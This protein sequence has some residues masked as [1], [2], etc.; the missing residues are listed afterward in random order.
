[1]RLAL[2][3]LF[4][5]L[6]VVQ[7][8]GQN[9]IKT[10]NEFLPHALGDQFTPHHLQVDYFQYLAAQAPS[11]MILQQY[12]QTY[13]ARPLQVAIIS[14]PE[15]ISRL[16]QIRVN[17]LRLA[18]LAEGSAD[19]I[20]PPAI[21]WLSM[22]VHGNEPSG[23]ECSMALA[24]RLATQKD[25]SVRN[26][27]KNTVVIIDPSL[28]PD[29]YDRY[30]HWNRMAGNLIKNPGHSS[31]EHRE[32]WPSGRVNHYYFDLNRDWA[33]GAQVETRHRLVLYQS[34]LPHIH[35]DLHEQYPENPYYFAPAAEPMHAYITPWQRDF[36]AEIG[37]NHAFYFDQSGWLY[38]T[39][40]V[41]D[42]FYP[43]YGDTYPIFNGSIGM[44]YEQAG[45]G[46]A[47]RAITLN[48][49]DT[50]T[51]YDRIAHHMTTSLS[52]IEMASKNAERVVTN[53]RQYYKNTAAQPQGPYKT[54]VIQAGNDPNKIDALCRLLDM[55]QIKYGFAGADHTNLKG[56][57]YREGKET[58]AAIAA[59][60]ILISAFQPKST[61]VQILF[62]PVGKLSDSLTYDITAWALPFAHG[63]DAF[64]LKER[65]D[66][67]K[68]YQ[69]IKAPETRIAAPPYA[70]CIHRRSMAEARF[71]SEILQKG[72]HARY[73]TKAFALADQQYEPGAIVINRGDNKVTGIDLDPLVMEIAKKYNVTLY[74]IFTGFAGAGPDLGAE[75][76]RLIRELKAALVYGEEADEGSFGHTWHYFEQELGHPLSVIPADQLAGTALSQF[77]TIIF[78]GGKYLLDETELGL[79]K[80]WVNNGG[81]LI[82]ME[83]AL[84]AF[85]DKE[86]FMLK[87]RTMQKDS[88]NRDQQAYTALERQKVSEQLPG[89]IVKAKCDPANPLTFGMGKIYFSLKTGPELYEMPENNFT[90]V[91]LDENFQSF[92][93]IG[94]KVAPLLKKSPVVMVEQSGNGQLVYF[95]DPP[96]FRGFWEQGKLLF[97]NALFF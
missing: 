82:A 61:L 69:K 33:W 21:V 45:H 2:V 66:P 19:L 89:A 27:L 54:F 57:N 76:F 9:A 23:A 47:G 38:F 80:E 55:H 35:A 7:S 30:T 16:E 11:T 32:P 68:P 52:T 5:S 24:H 43:S 46:V 3:F 10:P 1:M 48:N 67:K 83:L 77:N 90:P 78:A 81:R 56:F 37:R 50:L 93:F 42:L 41:F 91:Y 79:L 60:D 14:A 25:E 28:N 26:W 8:F 72:L 15:N 6:F 18:G 12:G 86:G 71:L 53:F 88:S 70:W 49:G 74:P 34:W 84:R 96:L 22:S 51:L 39:K 4:F 44:T 75:S 65:F 73:A 62:E 13:E 92:G 95:V 31:R 58:N 87:S 17:N 63:L 85:A 59:G 64:A 97:A 94:S 40:E 36:Q 29:G 20:N